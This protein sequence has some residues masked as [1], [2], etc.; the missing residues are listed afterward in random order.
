MATM[1]DRISLR[2]ALATWRMGEALNAHPS[3]CRLLTVIAVGI[4]VAAIALTAASSD[5]RVAEAAGSLQRESRCF[6]ACL[7]CSFSR[8]ILTVC[9]FALLHTFPVH[10]PCEGGDC[11]TVA[12]VWRTV[13]NTMDRTIKGTIFNQKHK[14]A[15]ERSRERKLRPSRSPEILSGQWVSASATIPSKRDTQ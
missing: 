9:L 12:G 5:R 15:S 10:R 14:H 6:R 4:C 3:R 7:L 2:G 8:Q 11:H 13:K 1:A